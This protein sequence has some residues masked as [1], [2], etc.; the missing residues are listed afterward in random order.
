M[1]QNYVRVSVY[2]AELDSINMIKMVIIQVSLT[3]SSLIVG[4]QLTA[5]N[6]IIKHK[7]AN[8]WP[9]RIDAFGINNVGDGMVTD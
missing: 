3:L 8:A 7:I 6:T 9:R 2:R 4:K 1:H 5:W